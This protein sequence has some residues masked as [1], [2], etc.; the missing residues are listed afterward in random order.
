MTEAE[1]ETQ[2][3]CELVKNFVNKIKDKTEGIILVGSL[4]YAP[5]LHVTN[6]SDIDLLVVYKDVK[7][8]LDDYFHEAKVLRQMD[9][10]GYLVKR[11]SNKGH[12]L[13][14]KSMN[15]HGLD[16]SIHN[17][18]LSSFQ[19]ICRG[20]YDRLVYYRQSKKGVPYYVNDFN[21]KS[22]PYD[23]LRLPVGELVGER[24]I[25]RVA[26]EN[27]KGNY[28]IGN[29]MNK[30]LS[31]SVVL[32]DAHGDIQKGLQKLWDNIALRIVEHRLRNN[33][34]LC[35]IE[36]NMMPCLYGREKFSPEIMYALKRKT[37]LFVIKTLSNKNLQLRLQNLQKRHGRIYE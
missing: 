9:F 23:T 33:Q 10:D 11:H 2:K 28:V 14:L 31:G 18:S 22:N 8:C 15:V 29:D 4:A 34:S 7:D 20:N 24:R 3:R 37:Q 36:S 13:D 35:Q 25:D 6:K 17:L 16:L 21:E 19:K 12:P 26:F 5:N 1:I 27:E 32:Y 30:L